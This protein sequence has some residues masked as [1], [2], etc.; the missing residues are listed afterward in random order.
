MQEYDY[1][2]AG[3]GA[4]GLQLAY[5]MSKDPFFTSKKILLLNDTPK[6]KN[7]RTWCFWE[8]GEG[9]FNDIVYQSWGKALFTSETYTQSIALKPYRYKMV[10]GI[11]FYRRVLANLIQHSSFTIAYEKVVE[12]KEHHDYVKVTTVLK[13]YKASKVL[14][15]IFNAKDLLN[16]KKYPVL[17]QHFIGWF[18]ETA[19]AIFNPD[20]VTFMDFRI[21]QNGNT[22]FMYVLPFSD[23]KALVEY[24]LF[25][26][27]L[28]PEKEYET[29]IE[30]Y[31]NARN[32][33]NFKIT[34]TESGSIPMTAFDFTKENT[35]RFLKIG[36]AG[37]WTK[38]STGYTFKSTQENVLKL[39]PLLKSGKSFKN[40]GKPNRFMLYDAILLD[41][42][43]RKNH[44]GAAIFSKLFK[45]NKPLFIFKFLDNKTHILEELS[46]MLS[47]ADFQFTKAFFRRIF[48]VLRRSDN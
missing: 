9:L 29:A 16:Q 5:A 40:F 1:I 37:G 48:R 20:E 28:L 12:I 10:K 11:D 42:L 26:E 27:K 34:D 46:I 33:G 22:R 43:H 17:Q 6:D 32:A 2:I 7:D 14:S 18:V 38:A 41:I 21:P 25:S 15:S 23:Q 19:N 47:V 30:N 13:E 3:A 39:I 8:E 44:L 36:I 35:S 45:N 24:T 4:A 31:L